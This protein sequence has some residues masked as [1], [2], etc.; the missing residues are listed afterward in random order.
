MKRQLK[1]RIVGMGSYLPKKNLTNYD[2]EK[3]VDTSD[4]WI[5]SRTGIKERR[6]AASDEYASDM[7][8]AAAKKAL[9]ASGLS[10][11]DIELILVA[12]LT[13]DYISPSTGALIQDLIQAENA[14]AMDIQ[15]ACTGFLYALSMAKAYIES[16]MYGKILVV[17]S[18]KLSTYIDY[19]D[20]GTCILFG[21]GAGAAVICNEG[22]GLA[23]DHTC[24]GAEGKLAQL[25]IIPGGGV[26]HPSSSETIAQG[27]HYLKMEG[28]NVFKQAVRRMSSS[29]KECLAHVD[30]KEE[31]I[32]WVVP[33][34][35]NM[36]ILDAIAKN[37]NIPGDRFYKTL[38]KYGNTSASSII[39][40][41]DEL[42]RKHPI[43]VGEHVLL[44][45]FGAGLT[46]GASV[47][48][49]VKR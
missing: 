25:V 29:A 13:P 44:I 40:S 30:V 15:A 26:R 33:H 41:L 49:Q 18:E 2:L 23:I 1:A 42:T 48:T 46:W 10:A 27:L 37:F 16:G 20:R 4:E 7:G 11:S 32:S 8:A 19:K 39:I 36:R 17:A 47:L 6:I 21:D 31:E 43:A 22:E 35:A 14:A 28:N 3:I 9:A 5:T 38:H 24:L 45:A 12:T 34:Q